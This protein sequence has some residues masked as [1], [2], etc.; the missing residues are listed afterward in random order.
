[1]EIH[2]AT[3]VPPGKCLVQTRKYGKKLPPERLALGEFLAGPDERGIVPEVL[4]P[5]KYYINPHAYDVAEQT[6]LEIRHF[7]VGVRTLLWGKD[8]R[9]LKDANRSVYVVPEDYRG[10]QEKP[11]PPGT[12]YF[13]P[14]VETI[15][16]IDTRSHR[17]E[18][19]DIRFPSL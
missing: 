5:G 18:F 10:V 4:L 3:I 12:Y 14:Y 11:V 19:K 9:E 6:A 17:V 8:P 15:V 2:K 7:Q 16:P 13:N 1:S